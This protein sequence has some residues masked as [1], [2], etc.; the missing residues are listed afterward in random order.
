MGEPDAVHYAMRTQMVCMVLE[1]LR[2]VA[3]VIILV[4]R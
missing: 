3:W 2:F 4:A 1:L